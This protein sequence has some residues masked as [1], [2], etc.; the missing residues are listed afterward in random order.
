M[1]NVIDHVTNVQQSAA[2]YT[3]Y[4]DGPTMTSPRIT[5]LGTGGFTL[6]TFYLEVS[7]SSLGQFVRFNDKL[8]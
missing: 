7:I 5:A 1:T 2:T 4:A 3:Y 6:L 8:D